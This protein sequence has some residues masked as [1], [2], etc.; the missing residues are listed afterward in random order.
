ME[1]VLVELLIV[2]KEKRYINTE[3]YFVDGIKVEANAN[4]YTF[5][6]KK[7]LKNI[8]LNYKNKYILWWKK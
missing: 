5:V 8:E 7:M 4:K 2:L 1:D 6:C 3:E